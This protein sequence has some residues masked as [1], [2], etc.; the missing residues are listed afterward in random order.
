MH[1][2]M[3]YRLPRFWILALVQL[4]L[5]V[6]VAGFC[7]YLRTAAFLSGP[8]SGDLYANSWSFQLVI[9]AAIW[10]P[11]ALLVAGTLIAIEHSLLKHFQR[12]P[13][14]KRRPHAH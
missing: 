4:L 2:G 11:A 12:L 5:A 9:F 14:T 8:P 7:F 3:T 6:A 10:L 13:A 1:T